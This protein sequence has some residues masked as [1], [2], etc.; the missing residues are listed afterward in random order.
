VKSS[1]TS[2]EELVLLTV[3]LQSGESYGYSIQQELE[4]QA[5]NSPG[6]ASIHTILHRLEKEG[7]LASSLGGASEKRGGRSKRLYSVSGAGFRLIREIQSIRL[8][9]WAQIDAKT[10]LEGGITT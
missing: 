1:L 3:A 5:G 8:D 9:I 2:R 6:L 10:R 4:K 7:L